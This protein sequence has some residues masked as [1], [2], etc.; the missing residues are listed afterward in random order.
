M[1]QNGGNDE[2]PDHSELLRNLQTS[3][4][5][6]VNRMR[7]DKMRGRSIANDSTVQ[8]LFQSINNMHP[9]LIQFMNELEEKRCK[10]FEFS[11]QK[12]C[13]L[14]IEYIYSYELW[15]LFRPQTIVSSTPRSSAR[16]ARSAERRES[17]IGCTAN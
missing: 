17:C 5:I 15:P 12:N 4:E 1:L 10:P 9:T 11:K 6:F 2:I 13:K 7:S 3:V 14:N 8:S 16:Q